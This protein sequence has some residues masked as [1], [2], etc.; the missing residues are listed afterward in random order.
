MREII[1]YAQQIDV[2]NLGPGRRSVVWMQG[3]EFACPNCIVKESWD[4]TKGYVK[5][6]DLLVGEII[7]DSIEGVT[8]SGGEPFLQIEALSAFI[9]NVKALRED[10]SIM[11]FTGYRLLDL[12][13]HENPKVEEILNACDILVDGLYRVQEARFDPWRGSQNQCIHFLTNR[14]SILD[15]KRALQSHS[16]EIYIKDKTLFAAG[17]SKEIGDL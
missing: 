15:Y 12:Q 7:G 5:D 11:I 3:C 13:I 10:L 14:Y 8:I 17:V 6:I 4:I 2:T 1:L 9:K 16:L